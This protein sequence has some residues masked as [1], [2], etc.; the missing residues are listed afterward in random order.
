M[1]ELPARWLATRKSLFFDEPTVGLDPK[2]ILEIRD[3]IRDL[4][5]AYDF[6]KFPYLAGDSAVCNEIIIIN[7]G[8]MIVKDKPE[9]I[10]AHIEQTHE[11]T[12]EIKGNKG[13]HRSIFIGH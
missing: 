12:M 10:S 2:Q 8:K 13:S 6:V 9:N 7:E 4:S 1:W 11:L 5:E 3:L